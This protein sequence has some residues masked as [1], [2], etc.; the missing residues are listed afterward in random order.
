MAEGRGQWRAGA[1]V[2]PSVA[3]PR[4][5]G[6]AAHD[7]S[8]VCTRRFAARGGGAPRGARVVDFAMALRTIAQRL[9]G[10]PTAALCVFRPVLPGTGK[11]NETPLIRRITPPSPAPVQRTNKSQSLVVG[12]DGYPKPPGR[13]GAN[14]NAQDAASVLASPTSVSSTEPSFRTGDPAR[15]SV[16]LQ[17]RPREAPLTDRTERIIIIIGLLSRGGR[18]RC[19]TGRQRSRSPDERSDIRERRNAA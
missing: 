13:A 1:I 14:R 3:R 12:P 10:A 8:E 5:I 15:R 19:G 4:A 7:A 2:D 6:L 18:V 17:K 9:V 11:G 16:P